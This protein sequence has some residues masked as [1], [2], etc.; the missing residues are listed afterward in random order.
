MIGRHRLHS[1]VNNVEMLAIYGVEHNNFYEVNC[2][3]SIFFD[4]NKTGF[5]TFMDPVT[6]KNHPNYRS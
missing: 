4:Q 6:N 3:V 1:Y 5:I 2:L